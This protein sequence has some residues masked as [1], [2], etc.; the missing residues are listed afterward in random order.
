MYVWVCVGE[1][2]SSLTANDDDSCTCQGHTKE[3]L[4]CSYRT[5]M[6]LE[7]LS[8][9]SSPLHPI[10][11]HCQQLWLDTDPISCGLQELNTGLE[12]SP[13]SRQVACYAGGHRDTTANVDSTACV[14]LVTESLT[15]SG[16]CPGSPCAVC[17]LLGD[18][19]ATSTEYAENSVRRPQQRCKL[20]P[21]GETP[22]PTPRGTPRRIPNSG[23]TNISA[24]SA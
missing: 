6:I 19:V 11:R 18:D 12:R 4:L 10:S 24:D 16:E 13:S 9:Y 3:P 2:R 5:P 22:S 17:R 23:L 7:D 1:R 14:P 8:C 21:Q 15:C 20:T